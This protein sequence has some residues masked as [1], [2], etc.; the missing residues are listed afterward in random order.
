[1]GQ[2]HTTINQNEVWMLYC[3]AYRITDIIDRVCSLCKLWKRQTDGQTDTQM[4]V[5]KVWYLGGY[6]F[7]LSHIREKVA[8]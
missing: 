1:M 4:E 8:T 2:G 7:I 3:V 6:S 5:L